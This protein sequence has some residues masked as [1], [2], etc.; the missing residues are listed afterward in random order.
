MGGLVSR[1]RQ[2]KPSELRARINSCNPPASV[3]FDVQPRVVKSISF[4]GERSHPGKS[5][6]EFRKEHPA[7]SEEISRSSTAVPSTK[8]SA[9]GGSPEGQGCNTETQLFKLDHL[10][11]SRLE[12]EIR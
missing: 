5:Q 8:N 2:K 1:G 12:A 11:P 3:L 7:L 9:S 10:F 4:Q 6:E